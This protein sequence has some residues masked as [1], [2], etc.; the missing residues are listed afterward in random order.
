MRVDTAQKD[1]T[2]GPFLYERE[3]YHA[4]LWAWAAR[5][6]SNMAQR[7]IRIMSVQFGT[8][9]AVRLDEL[10]DGQLRDIGLRRHEVAQIDPRA[11][12]IF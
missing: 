12:I 1:S 7:V 9:G 6:V 3:N 10:S 2:C 8:H 4:L 11:P 5:S